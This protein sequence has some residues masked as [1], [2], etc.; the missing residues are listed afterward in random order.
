MTNDCLEHKPLQLIFCHLEMPRTHVQQNPAA[1]FLART[2]NSRCFQKRERE[3]G[4][5]VE[6]PTF[7]VKFI[8]LL[9]QRRT[10]I[11]S[12]RC[13]DIGDFHRGDALHVTE[14]VD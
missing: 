14:G 11:P 10:R 3:P 9:L 1:T 6:H 12:K 5:G 7:Q 4:L 13:A 8:L 2:F